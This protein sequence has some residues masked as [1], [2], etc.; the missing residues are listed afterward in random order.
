MVPAAAASFPFDA[1]DD[2]ALD[3]SAEPLSEELSSGGEPQEVASRN[4]M[5]R[6]SRRDLA[7]F[8]GCP[9]RDKAFAL[10]TGSGDKRIR[11]CAP[12]ALR[13]LEKA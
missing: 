3:D 12:A 4:T 6:S 8:M 7:G 1:L 2:S 9:F 13:M 11:A 10:G 5:V